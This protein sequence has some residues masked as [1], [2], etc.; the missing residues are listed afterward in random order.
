MIVEQAIKDPKDKWIPRYFVMFFA[1]IVILDSIFVYIAVTTQ[2]GVVIENPYEKGIAYNEIL[3]KAKSQPDLANEVSYI[4]GVLYW[5][6][7]ITT[8]FVT[9][10]IFRPVQDGYDFDIKLT[11]IGDG[12]YK[13]KIKTPLPGL[14]VAKMKATWNNN[15]FQTTHEFIAK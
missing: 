2:T 6:L 5:K 15:H 14:W 3:E 8:A 11:Y 9:A 7:P 4:D 10:S 12:V 1:V 13:S